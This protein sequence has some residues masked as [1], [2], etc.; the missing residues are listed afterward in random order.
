MLARSRARFGEYT[1]GANSV[2]RHVNGSTVSPGNLTVRPE[3]APL[4]TRSPA[5]ALALLLTRTP[6]SLARRSAYPPSHLPI[7]SLALSSLSP[8]DVTL[9]PS[10]AP[11]VSQAGLIGLSS[12]RPVISQACHLAGLSSRRP[13]ISQAR[14]LNVPPAVSLAHRLADFA[15]YT[16][17]SAA[18]SPAC[19]LARVPSRPRAVSPA[20]RLARALLH[21]VQYT[22]STDVPETPARRTSNSTFSP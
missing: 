19:C 17:V 4:P 18:I 13:V 22:D 5:L 21:P 16:P 2:T 12:R 7:I 8:V 11:A 3:L 10:H 9:T 6:V 14:H 1:G 20:C 15:S